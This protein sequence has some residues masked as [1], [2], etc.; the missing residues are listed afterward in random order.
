MEL[1]SRTYLPSDAPA[2]CELAN[3][4][5]EHGGGH[6]RWTPDTMRSVVD[7]KIGEP[8]SDTRL[9]FAPDGALVASA[10][11]PT[12]PGGGFRVNLPGGV[13]PRWRSRGLGRE[14]LG[15][16][17]ARAAEIHRAVAPGARWEVHADSMLGDED[18]L[19]LYRR[20]GL[21]AGRYWIDM[22]AATA[23]APALAVP[24][25][26][27]L[28]AYAPAYEQALHAVHTEVFEE[29]WGY[30]RRELAEW[31]KVS[32]GLDIFRPDLSAVALDGASIA[33][34]LLCYDD[35]DPGRLYLGQL[36]VRRSWRRRGVAG[37]L[38]AHALRAAGEAGK[39]RAGLEVDAANPT[40]AVGLY[41]R[42]GFTV[43]TRAVTYV[44]PLPADAT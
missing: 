26:L 40:G 35:A 27:R 36:G 37:A 20:F 43:E 2:L 8:G 14:L 18:A 28:V 16:Q 5:D 15:W 22:A 19:R 39:P 17:L 31:V 7:A 33:G 12:P 25:G 41:E 32:V 34:Y 6:G 44:S 38:L 30:Q 10:L 3:R 21:T 29:H 4:I 24:D 13:H 23:T 11:V 1:T 42:V 9:V